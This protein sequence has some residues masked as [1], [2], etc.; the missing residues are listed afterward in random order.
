MARQD[1]RRTAGQD[2]AADVPQLNPTSLA[3]ADVAP[4]VDASPR[5]YRDWRGAATAAA[6]L[7]VAVAAWL[8]ASPFVLPY[9]PGDSRL[10]PIVVG[11][12]VGFVALVRSGAH[13]AEWLSAINFVAGA[14]LAISG[15]WLAA[16]PGASW[17]SWLTGLAVIMLALLGIDASEEGRRARAPAAR[18]EPSLR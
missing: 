14:W 1:R 16:S 13:R 3:P 17:N 15:F 12:V 7:N 6:L 2:P 5:R 9:V 8:I 10:N 4:Q 18:E 11:A